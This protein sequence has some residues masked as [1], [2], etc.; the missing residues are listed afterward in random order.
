M[1]IIPDIPV[2]TRIDIGIGGE[3]DNW[4]GQPKYFSTSSTGK[5]LGYNGHGIIISTSSNTEY[6]CYDAT[7]TACLDLTSSFKQEDLNGDIAKCSVCETEFLLSLSYPINTE[8]EISPLKP[9]PITRA[10]DVLIVSYK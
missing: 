8:I 1:H 2:N 7:C 3:S 9:Y 5:P 6:Q 4:I 10:G